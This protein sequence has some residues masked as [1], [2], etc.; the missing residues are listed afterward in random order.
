MTAEQKAKL[1]IK[2]MKETHPREMMKADEKSPLKVNVDGFFDF[3][4]IAARFD[5]LVTGTGK[6]AQ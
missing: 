5:E 2:A 6:K 1:L 4:A 3:A